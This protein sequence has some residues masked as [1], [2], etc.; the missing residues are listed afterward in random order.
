[1]LLTLLILAIMCKVHVAYGPC[2]WPINQ[3]VFCSSVSNQPTAKS[4]AA[5]WLRL[6]VPHPFQMSRKVKDELVQANLIGALQGG[7][8][9]WL[10]KWSHSSRGLLLRRGRSGS[11]HGRIKGERFLT[12]INNT[13]LKKTLSVH[14][15]S[16]GVPSRVTFAWG[17]KPIL[18][19]SFRAHEGQTT[20]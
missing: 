15:N 19:T 11:Q 7:D 6:F 18:N 4:N 9:G 2:I 3:Q 5:G 12:R 10:V 1:M 17:E 20:T 8:F 16:Y 14:A 13:R